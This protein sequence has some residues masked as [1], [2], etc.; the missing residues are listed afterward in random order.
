M[1][2]PVG[3]G[4]YLL[5]TARRARLAPGKADLPARPLP[6][7][8]AGPLVWF[9]LDA[10]PPPG[11]AALIRRL[12]DAVHPPEILVTA[13]G[14]ELSATV[15]ALPAD[16]L[17]LPAPP[18][19]MPDMR[20][21]LAHWRPDL[22]VLT[23][24]ALP[25]ALIHEAVR[26]RV[27][28]HW[29][30]ARPPRPGAPTR[31]PGVVSTL[32]QSLAQ[33][34]TADGRSARALRRL[35]APE[36]RIEVTGALHEEPV[37]LPY[38]EAE[39]E[40]LAQLARARPIWLAVCLPEEEEAAVIEAHRRALR[41]AHRLLLIAVPEDP[42]RAGALAAKME[43]GQGW[44]VARRSADEEP[45]EE[46]QAYIADTEGELGLWYRLAPITYLGGSLTTGPTRSPL[47]AAALGS[48]IVH[49]PRTGLHGDALIRLEAA[50]ATRPIARPEAL[51][52]A[53]ADLIAPDRAAHLAHNAWEASTAGADVT[54]RLAA[55]IQSA[56]PAPRPE[57]APAGTSRQQAAEAP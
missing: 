48:A 53:V 33:I 30:G 27:P 6:A 16:V 11:L 34:A 45:E 28:V 29:I 52:E 42:A 54:D 17:T 25:A 49:G 22:V 15:G 39:R 12:Q 19:S 3:L 38:V 47:E 21:H 32:L 35:G 10:A 14:E 41:K 4:L 37:I 46:M 56:L 7:R 1:A 51:G 40:A 24:D 13:P 5:A 50:H 55:M 31:F 43:I 57:D 2:F 9:P 8:P 36:N 26:A 20:A 44:T 18:A 23:G